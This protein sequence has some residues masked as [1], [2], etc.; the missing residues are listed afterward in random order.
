LT[1]EIY[2]LWSGAPDDWKPLNHSCDPNAWLDGLN[3][4][5]R[6]RIQSGEQITA[7][8]GTFCNESLEPFVCSCGSPECRGTIRGTDY[9]SSF[10]HRYGEHVSDYVRSR[11][12]Q[13][14]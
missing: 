1:D 3:L 12:K 6:R 4:V 2:V 9:R 10:V 13:I 8:Y 11:R 14:S 5:A 7:D